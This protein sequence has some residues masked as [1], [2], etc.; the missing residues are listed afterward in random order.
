MSLT[1]ASF[2]MITG[3]PVNVLDYGVIADGTTNNT[4]ALAAALAAVPTNGTL[5][6]PAGVYCGYLLLR[7]SNITIMGDG[8]AST[9]LKLPTSCPTIT[10][11]AEGGGTITGLPNV[12]E[13]GECALGNNAN[14]Y[15]KINIVGLTIDGNYA[16]NTAPTTDLFGHGVILTKSSYCFIDDVI[17]QNC[18]AT[19]IDNVINSNYNTINAICIACGNATISGGNYPNF[20]INSSKY[21]TFNITSYNGYYGG[22]MLD[23]C[24]NNT[25]TLRAS[26]PSITGL[27]YN[28]QSV[29]VSYNNIINATIYSGCTNGQGASVGT[30]C[31]NSTLNISVYGV[32]GAGILINGGSSTTTASGNICNFITEN[33]GAIGVTVSTYATYNQFNITSNKDGRTG[34]VGSNFAIDVSGDYNQFTAIIKEGTVSQVRGLVFR[35][36]AENNQVTSFIADPNLVEVANDFG[37]GNYINHPSGVGVSIASATTILIPFA[38]TL[39][40][41]TGTT[42]IV[43]INANTYNAGR[44]VTLQFAASVQVAVSGNIKLTGNTAFNATASDT[45]TLICDGTSWIEVARAVI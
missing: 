18:F 25:F 29:N 27:V 10:V 9:T 13:V 21:G 3:A 14:I 19:G 40:P 42:T 45:L 20:D 6:F 24:W 31:T 8:S 35:A 30:N 41:I 16:N 12:I 23:N 38:G 11:P 36:A 17:A 7:K 15:S 34:S 44:T 33:C 5:Y 43:T 28:N 32:V 2:S 37:T 4:T 26:N 22:R 1:K 39:I